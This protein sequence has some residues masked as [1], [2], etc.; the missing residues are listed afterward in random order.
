MYSYCNI[1]WVGFPTVAHEESHLKSKEHLLN[2]NTLFNHDTDNKNFCEVCVLQLNSEEQLDKHSFSRNHMRKLFDKNYILEFKV[3][4]NEEKNKRNV[5][6]NNSNEENNN[7][8]EENNKSNEENNNSNEKNNNSNEENNKSNEENNKSYEENNKRNVENNKLHKSSTFSGNLSNK[9]DNLVNSSIHHSPSFT[10]E[11]NEVCGL[12]ENCEICYISYSSKQHKEQH[13]DGQV[14]KKREEVFNMLKNSKTENIKNCCSVCYLIIPDM[15][16]A[17]LNFHLNGDKHKKS[18]VLRN[19]FC[20]EDEK[21]IKPLKQSSS[22]SSISSFECDSDTVSLNKTKSKNISIQDAENELINLY[23]NLEKVESYEFCVE[24][25]DLFS[26]A[27][28]SVEMNKKW[29]SLSEEMEKIKENLN[30]QTHDE[31]VKMTSFL[32]KHF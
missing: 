18:V 21:N 27:I 3:K 25:K 14:H 12:K 2:Q 4:R 31:W 16:T 24:N 1:C 29:K 28:I 9:Q 20:K 22:S 8:N 7:S 30:K 19:Q 17:Q 10:T 6:N 23:N 32:K 15:N 5:E 13:L 26:N 11:K